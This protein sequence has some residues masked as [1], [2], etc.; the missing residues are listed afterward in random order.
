MAVLIDTGV[1][2]AIERGQAGAAVRNALGSEERM[3][4]VITASELLHGV[5]R[6]DEAHRAA[7]SAHIE[8]VLASVRIL[9]VDMR[10]ARIHAGVW[11]D[12]ASRGEIIGPHDLW[13]AATALANHVGLATTNVREFSRIAGLRV[14]PVRF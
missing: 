1:L 11:A 3:I 14:V 13:I 6:A 7:R 10:V 8:E 2:V 5:R 12:L 4:S 9:G